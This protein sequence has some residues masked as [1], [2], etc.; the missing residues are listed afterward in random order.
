MKRFKE[1]DY[2]YFLKWL[3]ERQLK[4]KLDAN[5]IRERETHPLSDIEYTIFFSYR[6]D[7]RIS[8]DFWV[9]VYK[10]LRDSYEDISID[11]PVVASAGTFRSEEIHDVPLTDESSDKHEA[12][13]NEIYRDIVKCAA[14]LFEFDEQGLKDI[15]TLMCCMNREEEVEVLGRALSK[16]QKKEF[17]IGGNYIENQLINNK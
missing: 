12:I 3:I 16:L 2:Y 13:R 8:K 9:D 7:D 4:T 14:K 5:D 10:Y 1:K 11:D 17:N 15:R 6:E